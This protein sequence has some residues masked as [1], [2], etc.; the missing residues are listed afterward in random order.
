VSVVADQQGGPTSALDIADAVIAVARR[1]TSS[2]YRKGLTG[3]F[4][5]TG[6]GEAT[7]AGFAEAIFAEA[8]AHG[9]KRVAVR[10]ITTARGIRRRRAA[11][12]I[13]G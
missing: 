3:V 1:I 10:P 13:P 12:P 5:M 11:R 7:W 9:R 6:G 2:R 8:S 4:H